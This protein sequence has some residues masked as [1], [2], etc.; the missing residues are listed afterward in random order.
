MPIYKVQAP[1]GSII[2]IEGPEGATDEQLVQAAAAGWTPPEKTTLAQDIKQGAGNLVAGAIRGAGS[3]GATILYPW[4]KAQDLYYGDREQNL[5]SLITGEK[6]LSRNEERR[7]AM[8]DALGTLGAETDSWMYKGGKLAGEIAGT[9]GAGG[10]TANVLAKVAPKAAAAAP[11]LIEAL[12]TGGMASGGAGMGTR[13]AGGAINGA[14]QA[15]LVDPQDAATGALIGGAMPVVVKGFSMAG[16]AID[17]KLQSRMA[18]KLREFNRAA[19]KN[20]TIRESVEAGYKIPPNMVKPSFGNRLVESVSGKQATQQLV[21][22]KNEE[23]TGSLVRKALGLPDDAQLTQST[24]EQ[25][26]K[27]AGTA[28]KQVADLSDQAAQDLEA[29]KIARNEASGWFKAYNRSAN[30]VDL[31][32]AKEARALTETLEQA[33]EKH[34]A[35]AGKDELIPALRDARKLIAKTYTVGRALNDAAGTVDARVLGRM[36]EKGLPLSDGL[37]TVGRFASAFPT[38]AKSQQQVGSPAAHNLNAWLTG[39]AGTGGAIVGGPVGAAL[40]AGTTMAAPPIARALMLRKGAQ[41]AL[42]QAAPEASKAAQLAKLLQNPELQQ[43]LLKSA[44]VMAAQ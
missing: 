20:E 10:A 26:R 38:I 2:K 12:R 35:D 14:I 28:Y 18:D 16:K 42:V 13:V 24:M 40:A 37:E 29:L 3:I 9:A 22:A 1:D 23:V 39:G 15:G 19:P 30:P 32:K 33:L 27:T 21:S 11:G 41:E 43:L 17:D 34:A 31:A 7:K 8:D 44:P 36:Y 5:S 4:D 25:L 6:P